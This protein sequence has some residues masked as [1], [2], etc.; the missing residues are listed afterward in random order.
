MVNETAGLF[1]W[2]QIMTRY[3]M[4]Y[5]PVQRRQVLGGE[6]DDDTAPSAP[7]FPTLPQPSVP[8]QFSGSTVP[9]PS[10]PSILGKYVIQRGTSVLFLAWYSA[11]QAGLLILL[12]RVFGRSALT[13]CGS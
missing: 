8:A 3:N 10:V 11:M 12:V 6:A 2:N 1:E 4:V 5:T 7:P 9:L 13:S